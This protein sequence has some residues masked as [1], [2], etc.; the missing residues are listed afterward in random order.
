MVKQ[1]HT[2]R[3][4]HCQTLH[5]NDFSIKGQKIRDQ[6]TVLVLENWLNSSYCMEFHRN[7]SDYLTRSKSGQFPIQVLILWENV[8]QCKSCWLIDAIHNRSVHTEPCYVCV[9]G[10]IIE[11]MRCC[12]GGDAWWLIVSTGNWWKKKTGGG[13]IG[14]CPHIFVI[15]LKCCSKIKAI[16]IP[17]Y[18]LIRSDNSKNALS[19][20]DFCQNY[21]VHA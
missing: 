16:Y 8:W 10:H 20:N 9:Y 13:G 21:T 6:Y 2:R 18:Q 7:L 17:T 14:T 15:H 19:K 12:Y 4:W 5:V 11:S 1:K 3:L